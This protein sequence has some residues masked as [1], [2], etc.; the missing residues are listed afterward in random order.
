MRP[1]NN[2]EKQAGETKAWRCENENTVVEML[3]S[4]EEGK[5]MTF[6]FVF[7][8]SH[9]TQDVYAKISPRILNG[10]LRG[11]NGTIFAYGQTSSGKTHTLMGNEKEPGL[12]VMAVQ[13]VF[14][15]VLQLENHDSLIRVSYIEIYNEEIRDLLREVRSVLIV[16]HIALGQ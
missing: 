11:C 7:D 4:G 14:A 15:S 5:S 8:E 6:D 10:V 13:D 2:K 12:I 3:P 9:A 1:L 16:S